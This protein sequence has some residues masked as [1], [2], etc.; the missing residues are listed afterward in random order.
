MKARVFAR[1]ASYTL[2]LNKASVTKG[3]ELY[4]VTNVKD[5]NDLVSKYDV[6]NKT[7]SVAVV[8]GEFTLDASAKMPSKATFK[9]TTNITVKGNV[10]MSNVKVEGETL[11]VKVGKDATLTTGAGFE[12]TTIENKGIVNIAPVKKDGK[13]IEYNLISK[14]ENDGAVN[15]LADAI[16]AFAL[17]NKINANTLVHG[18]FVNNGVATVDLTN[19][20]EV[21]NEGTLNLKGN[22]EVKQIVA[23]SNPEKAFTPV[24]T[25][26]K[27]VLAVGDFNNYGKFLNS[28]GADVAC[29]EGAGTFANAGFAE[30]KDGSSFLITSNSDGGE[31]MIEKIAQA[32]YSVPTN[33]G[34]ISCA[35]TESKLKMSSYK[36]INKLYVSGNFELEDCGNVKDVEVAFATS[37][38]LTL[39]KYDGSTTEKAE[40]TAIDN[41]TVKSGT[42][43]IASADAKLSKL[44]VKEGAKALVDQNNKVEATA[45]EVEKDATVLVGGTFKTETKQDAEEIEGSVEST[46]AGSSITFGKTNVDEMKEEY[47]AKVKRMVEAVILANATT[48]WTTV[49]GIADFDWSENASGLEGG[50]NLNVLLGDAFTA[51]NDWMRADGK[52]ELQKSEYE[53]L[54]TKDDPIFAAAIKAYKTAGDASRGEAIKAKIKK[55]DWFETTTVYQKKTADAKLID[56]ATVPAGMET[57]VTMVSAFAAKV[58]DFTIGDVKVVKVP[59]TATA[60]EKDAANVT[61]KAIFLSLKAVQGDDATG[62]NKANFVQASWIPAYS[63]IETYEEADAY[64]VIKALTSFEA[65]WYNTTGAD[66]GTAFE[67]K[68]LAEVKQA[69]AL[70]NDK[71]NMTGSEAL[72]TLEKYK[73][74]ESGILNYVKTVLGWE[75]ADKQIEALKEIVD[76]SQDS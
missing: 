37:G 57:A 72:G 63:Y 38:K 17:E 46:G 42:C 35:P 26:N 31:V 30:V 16:A 36:A 15:V 32:G 27:K 14:I 50:T 12:A 21:T 47:E 33:N 73:I 6:A 20:G 4:I 64:K 41:L 67:F 3:E 53:T 62:A 22:N 75:Y 59:T 13:V 5:W 29:K 48:T 19:Y 65:K 24:I 8:G 55:N 70:I 11:K 2:N 56:I 45:L 1:N 49:E 28:K 39:P 34:F 66:G 71:Y 10:T 25:N 69:I 7:V 54:V 61:N 60:A 18:V 74:E 76:P 40:Y 51:Y 23:N 9:V 43:S 52:E 68:T 58:N 44:I